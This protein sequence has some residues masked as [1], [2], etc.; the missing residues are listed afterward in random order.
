MSGLIMVSAVISATNA[1][2]LNDGR[3]ATVPK[4]GWLSFEF[5]ASDAVAANHY[6]ATI[7][8]PD[9]STPLQDVWVPGG[10]TAGLAGVMD[11]RLALKTRFRISQGGTCVLSLTE[12]GDAECMYRVTFTP[13]PGR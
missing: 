2:V 9:N 12:T 13:F 3:L 7:Q 6:K 10:G 4:N 11:D 1:S 5:I 8:L